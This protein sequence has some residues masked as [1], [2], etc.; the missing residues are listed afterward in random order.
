MNE[1]APPSDG[2]VIVYDG[3]CPF[4]SA[5]VRLLRL[6]DSV[7]GVRLVDAR[8]GDPAVAAALAE[9]HDLDAGMVVIYGGVSYHGSRA[10]HLLA[11]LSGPSGPVNRVMGALF[12]RAWLARWL[13]PVL[14]A[15]RRLTLV[16]LG[17]P[18]IRAARRAR[19]GDGC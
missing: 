15:G 2:M 13:Y 5:Y 19:A 1:A 12:R 16:L 17:R 8:S 9:G 4:C 14:A 11:M 10:M 7:G 6:R 18:T 3:E